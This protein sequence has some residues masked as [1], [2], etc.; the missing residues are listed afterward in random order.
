MRYLTLLLLVLVMPEALAQPPYGTPTQDLGEHIRRGLEDNAM[1]LGG[2]IGA[3]GAGV[4]TVWVLD[5]VGA[6]TDLKVAG[7]YV[8][9][10]AGFALGVHGAA[11]LIGVDGTLR[12]AMGDVMSGVAI[13]APAGA[14]LI[15]LLDA[16]VPDERDP[17][18]GLICLD[19]R[20]FTIAALGAGV[21]LAV[22]ITW[23]LADYR[24]TAPV[25]LR[26][27]DG[28]PAPGLSLSFGL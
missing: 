10:A 28:K 5:G 24:N 8:A 14:A 16:T 3:M 1:V 26:R 9:G 4:T 20:A 17:C 2:G 23:V 15:F 12:N 7:G 25:I 18:N 11:Q 21:A 6:G 13:G 22:P 19:S 27:P